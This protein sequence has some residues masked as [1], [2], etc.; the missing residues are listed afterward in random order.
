M[1]VCDL[2]FLFFSLYVSSESWIL[3]RSSRSIAVYH[4]K[5]GS[6]EKNDIQRKWQDGRTQIIICTIAFGMGIDVC[7][8]FQKL[9]F[10]FFTPKTRAH[11]PHFTFPSLAFSFFLCFDRQKGNVRFVV[12]ESIGDSLEGFYQESGRAGRDG[13]PSISVV[14]Y[15]LQDREKKRFLLEQE[16]RAQQEAQKERNAAPDPDSDR[17]WDAVERSFRQVS[18]FFSP[19]CL[20]CLFSISRRM[21]FGLVRREAHRVLRDAKMPKKNDR[22]LFWREIGHPVLQSDLRL[23]FGS[24]KSQRTH[25]SSRCERIRLF[26]FFFI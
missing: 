1:P 24:N 20:F 11:N 8:S 23:L 5:L 3:T 9:F 12:H 26:S 10:F 7:I 13:L 21:C 16:F 18:L 4:A 15:S 14:F 6:K 19:L 17:R 25:P 22:G 2:P